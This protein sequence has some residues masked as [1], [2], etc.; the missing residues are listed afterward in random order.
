MY[1]GT[2]DIGYAQLNQLS[3]CLSHIISL[4]Q[5][6]KFLLVQIVTLTVFLVEFGRHDTPRGNDHVWD[7]FFSFSNS[8]EPSE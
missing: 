8:A 3:V 7:I 2:F 4:L 1:D 5:V 6:G